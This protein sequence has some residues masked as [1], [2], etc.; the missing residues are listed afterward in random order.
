MENLDTLMAF[1]EFLDDLVMR[2]GYIGIVVAMMAESAGIPFA[3]AL[4]ILTAGK[5]IAT[6]KITI[7]GAI[8][9]SVIG[10][11]LGSLISYLIGYIGRRL[12]TVINSTILHR[13]VKPIPYQQTKIKDLYDKYGNF[14]LIIAQLIGTT[15]TFISFPAGAMSMNIF[16]FTAYT[17]V[18]G[19][20]FSVFAIAASMFLNKILTVFFRLLHEILAL[21]YWI[22]PFFL[23]ALIIMVILLIKLWNKYRNRA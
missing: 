10:I 12:G 17:T 19:I 15:R 11:T 23:L 2:Y 3:S 8:F 20:I 5:L 13:K 16:L 4:V 6:G 18:G 1:S 22:W 14:A 9:A 21:P 7:F